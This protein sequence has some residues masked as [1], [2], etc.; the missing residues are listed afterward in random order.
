MTRKLQTVT[1]HAAPAMFAVKVLIANGSEAWFGGFSEEQPIFED[2]PAYRFT[3][4]SLVMLGRSLALATW[5]RG[6]PVVRQQPA[7]KAE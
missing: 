6:V 2:A 4:Q 3:A 1:V 5:C 7:P